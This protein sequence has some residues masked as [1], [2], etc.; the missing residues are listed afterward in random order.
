V[1][2]GGQE[3]GNEVRPAGAAA[4]AVDRLSAER[5]QGGLTLAGPDGAH[6]T[7]LHASLPP[8][9]DLTQALEDASLQVCAGGVCLASH[10]HVR[11]R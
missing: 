2:R 4:D 3:D 5:A 10:V 1:C 11:V 8:E 9:L 6:R 7:L